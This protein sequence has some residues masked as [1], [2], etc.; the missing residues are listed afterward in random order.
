VEVVTGAAS[1]GQ[2][3]ETVIAQICAETLGVDY[4]KVRVLHGD[5]NRIPYGFGAH[6]SRVTVMT[7]EATRLAAEMIRYKSIEAASQILQT[8]AE[9][10]DIVDGQIVRYDGIGPSI[11]L[12]VLAS[13]L[14]SASTL[15][16]DPE[17]GLSATSWFHNKHMNHPYGIHIPL[18]VVDRETGGV[19]IEQYAIAY[20]V[21]RAINPAL[22]EAQIIGGLAQGLGGALLEE[23]EYDET[24]QPIS[25]TLADYLI[26]TATEMPPVDVLIT[27]DAP[28]PLNPLGIKG[29]GEGG[30]NA[31]G[32]AIASAIDDALQMP[33][34]VDRL[35]VTPQYL[36]ARIAQYLSEIEK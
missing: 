3:M 6:A 12:G 34:L 26:A 11:S 7:G 19:T 32:A 15:S 24:G 35:P 27:E 17:P 2:G 36:K 18:V 31:A 21:G 20:D 23:F 14:G 10:L 4:Q 8:K 13:Q 28:S 5:T 9:E 30:V 22:V 33:G 16:G 25:V 1:L 29:A